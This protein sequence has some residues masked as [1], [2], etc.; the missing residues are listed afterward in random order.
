[1][2]E[3]T[4]ILLTVGL[5]TISGTIIYVLGRWFEKVFLEPLIEFNRTVGLI[6]NALYFYSNIYMT[7]SVAG[8][9]KLTEVRHKFRQYSSDLIVNFYSIPWIFRKVACPSEASIYN[10]KKELLLLSNSIADAPTSEISNIAKSIVC[11]LKLPTEI[12]K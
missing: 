5:T 11:N 12:I 9:E 1:M 2:S 4:K 6:A 7:P 10:T 3:L 8:T